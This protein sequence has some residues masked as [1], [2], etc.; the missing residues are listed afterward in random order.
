MI[1]PVLEFENIGFEIG[2]EAVA[3]TKFLTGSIKKA[4]PRLKK[5]DIAI[6]TEFETA[7]SISGMDCEDFEIL[8]SAICDGTAY[9]DDV[10][11]N[12][13]NI[14]LPLLGIISSIKSW[15]ELSKGV[16]CKSNARPLTRSPE[17][18]V[19][20]DKKQRWERRAKRQDY[21]WASPWYCALLKRQSLTQGL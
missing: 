10:T 6:I 4:L 13:R 8:C 9:I 11:I 21:M 15:K 5:L 16:Y 17:R 1:P 12:V 2:L 7:S 20:D 18:R 19:S 3:W 14:W